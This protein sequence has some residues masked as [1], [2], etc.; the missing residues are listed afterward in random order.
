MTEIWFVDVAAVRIQT[1]LAR[2]GARLRFRRGASFCLADLT[3]ADHLKTLLPP[4]LPVAPNDEA[5]NLSGVAS[6]R[7]PSTGLTEDQARA[8]ALEAALSVAR[9]IRSVFPALPLQALWGRGSSYVEAYAGEMRRRPLLFDLPTLNQEGVASRPCGM[10]R[11]ARAIHAGVSFIKHGDDLVDLCVDC[12]SRVKSS[13]GTGQAVAGWLSANASGWLPEAQK[14]LHQ[15]LSEVTGEGSLFPNDFAD[16]AEWIPKAEGD[17]ATQLCTIFADGNRIGVLMKAV[18]EH[19]KEA[20]T[21]DPTAKDK[22]KTIVAGIT[23]AT[24][25]SVAAAAKEAADIARRT[26]GDL[27][28]VGLNRVP[29]LVH[30]A[31][32]D[33]VLMTVPAPAGW[34]AARSL[35]ETF[36]DQLGGTVIE[37]GLPK[38]LQDFSLSMGMVFH[39]SSHPF[40]DVVVAA[41]ELLSAAKKQVQGAKASIAFLDITADGETSVGVREGNPDQPRRAVTLEEL[42][43]WD[44]TLTAAAGVDASQRSNLVQ[45]LRETTAEARETTSA[46][47]TPAGSEDSAA[48]TSSP[49]RETARAA[50]ARRVAT[51]GQRDILA[52]VGGSSK[53]PDKIPDDQKAFFAWVGH[54]RRELESDAAVVR[55]ELRLRLDIAR[56]WPTAAL[57]STTLPTETPTTP[58]PTTVLESA[59]GASS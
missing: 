10:C 29:A 33:D 45:L 26:A 9:H 7:F 44:A 12:C 48:P 55:D 37:A 53:G 59:E 56:W 15:D 50:L 22:R 42:D 54:I 31:D 3:A 19:L 25:R 52:L 20:G 57:K 36:A 4:G 35:G 41:E 49:A 2:S 6:L 27:G 11:T 1:W 47:A 13:D 28:G 24:R 58:A 40:A 16:L 14:R 21:V 32:G 34:A 39:H 5:G 30:L 18:A 8:I 17:A 46:A 38:E 23:Q 51:V 43:A